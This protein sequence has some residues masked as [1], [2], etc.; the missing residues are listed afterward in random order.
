MDAEAG[1]FQP[2]P[3]SSQRGGDRRSSRLRLRPSE[4]RPR[5]RSGGVLGQDAKQPAQVARRQ[6]H[7]LI[8]KRTRSATP[9]D[10]SGSQD[11]PGAAA[12]G[13]RQGQDPRAASPA[14]RQPGTAECKRSTQSRPRRQGAAPQQPGR[15]H[16]RGKLSRECPGGARQAARKG[17][18]AFS[19][20]NQIDVMTSSGPANAN[21]TLVDHSIKMGS[22]RGD[23]G[24][25]GNWNSA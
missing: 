5:H 4:R 13:T 8:E 2:S 1:T 20:F 14:T 15:R 10:D 7:L 11:A 22:G 24:W 21:T 17:R 19:L 16:S 18:A 25:H 6:L 12:A 23:V 3:L 9:S